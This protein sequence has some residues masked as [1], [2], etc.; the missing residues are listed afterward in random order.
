MPVQHTNRRGKTYWLHRGKTKTG[1]PK[2]F[3]SPKPEGDL[4]ESVPAGYEIYE[5][6]NAQVH[7][8]KA[9]PKLIT[10]A[11][12]MVVEKQLEKLHSSMSYKIDVKGKVITI[13]ESNESI[14]GMQ[15][16]FSSFL[17]SRQLPDTGVMEILEHSASYVPIMRLT[18]QDE[19]RRTFV[20]E[21]FCFRGSVEGWIFIGGSDSL[22][23]VAGKFIPHL[24]Q[25]S[26]YELY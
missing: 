16:I 9:V 11:E 10:E 7:L 23:V 24:G 5:N 22:E 14:G 4:V 3:F 20:V 6:P 13:F 17:S 21:R 2:Y 19:N 8:I 1:K 25:T 18:L 12:K 26:F 15:E